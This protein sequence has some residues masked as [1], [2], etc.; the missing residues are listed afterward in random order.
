VRE[1]LSFISAVIL[2]DLDQQR[3]S[4]SLILSLTPGLIQHFRDQTVLYKHLCM[5][6]DVLVYAH[7]AVCDLNTA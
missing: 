2:R 3:A 1:S 7:T 4:S 5:S 6:N